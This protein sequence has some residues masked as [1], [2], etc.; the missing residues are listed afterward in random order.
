MNAAHAKAW[1]ECNILHRDIS[2]DSILIL[3]MGPLGIPDPVTTIEILADW[4]LAAQHPGVDDPGGASD[5]ADHVRDSHD[6]V[7]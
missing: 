3:D 7:P 4:E 1:R 5:A 2:A 6:H